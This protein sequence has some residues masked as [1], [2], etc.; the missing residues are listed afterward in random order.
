MSLALA[1]L[2]VGA[3]SMSVFAT[4]QKADPLQA[5]RRIS[6]IYAERPSN[7][8]EELPCTWH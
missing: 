8:R 6:H 3:P 7:P 1:G 2:C 5:Y 4:E